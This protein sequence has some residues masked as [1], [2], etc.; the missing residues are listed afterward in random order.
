MGRMAKSPV[1]GTYTRDHVFERSLQKNRGQKPGDFSIDSRTAVAM[2][3]VEALGHF[4]KHGL[5]PKEHWS[6]LLGDRLPV[7]LHGK[8]RELWTEYLNSR[9]F[10]QAWAWAMKHACGP[11]RARDLL[12]YHVLKKALNYLRVNFEL[13]FRIGDLKW[14]MERLDYIMGCVSHGRD[15]PRSDTEKLVDLVREAVRETFPDN[16]AI[17]QGSTALTQDSAMKSGRLLG[18]LMLVMP[19]LH[20]LEGEYSRAVRDDKAIPNFGSWE[21]DIKKSPDVVAFW[22]IN[23]AG[24]RKELAEAGC[25]DPAAATKKRLKDFAEFMAAEVAGGIHL[26]RDYTDLIRSGLTEAG[27]APRHREYVRHGIPQESYIQSAGVIIHLRAHR[28]EQ[29][30]H[31][32][33]TAYRVKVCAD[34]YT[35]K[36]SL[37]EAFDAE[38]QRWGRKKEPRTLKNEPEQSNYYLEEWWLSE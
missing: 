15:L 21:R 32:I 27:A 38:A 23:E 25:R 10:D 17:N 37:E 6:D 11:E 24:H 16:P 3:P 7:H 5:H 28:E 36:R 20:E 12:L 26:V 34:E 22:L 13:M 19:V 33:M 35:V 8:A 1:K 30:K 2:Q 18:P 29:G 4:A 14:N 9:S 31:Q